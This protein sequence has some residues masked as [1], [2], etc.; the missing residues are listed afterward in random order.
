MSKLPNSRSVVVE[1]T[2][3]TLWS[4]DAD[5]TWLLN[6]PLRYVM[7]AD[8]AEELG[9]R[10]ASVSDLCGMPDYRP[11]IH[12]SA[13][14]GASILVE[15]H[16]NRGVGDVL[17]LSGPLSYLKDQSSGSCRIFFYGSASRGSILQGH[18]ALH[19][20]SVL[21][22]PISYDSLGRYNYHWFV[23]QVTE[24]SSG[25]DQL[26]VYDALYQSLGLD[27][28]YVPDKY[29]KPSLTLLPKDLT[30]REAYFKI[31]KMEKGVDLATEPYV[32]IAPACGSTLRSAPY[33]LWLELANRLMSQGFIVIM[34]GQV[35]GLMPAAGCSFDEFYAR[36]VEISQNNA[37]AIN[38]LGQ[39]AL[40]LGAALIEKARALFC[41][42][43]G[44]LYVAQAQQVPAISLWGTHHPSSRLG[45]DR[46]YM[47]LAILARN[48]CPH[49]PCYA[50]AGF[51][52]D[53]CPDGPEQRL[54]APLTA[55]GLL[56]EMLAKFASVQKPILK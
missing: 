50:Y 3:P 9:D 33:Q 7:N 29:K 52:T 36:W 26:N 30:L 41:L 10:I 15:R 6:P 25:A 5:E 12:I 56:D 32:V 24:Y 47:D 40:R 23:D 51:P 2:K 28:R 53:K 18:P 16:R 4:W 45:Y 46:P 20:Q 22:G 17:F 1:V 44:L 11:K 27:H 39:P 13:L 21:A 37:K 43:S 49:A 35:G 54:C 14:A 38:S 19:Q 34:L 42:D 8:R 55:P 48:E 31:T